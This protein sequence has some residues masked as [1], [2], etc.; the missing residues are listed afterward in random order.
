MKKSTLTILILLITTI[1][2]AQTSETKYFNS[3]WLEKEV[4]E[5]KAKF[6]QTIT[7]NVDG[8]VTTEVRDLKKNT[9][10]SSETFKGN[11]P[12]GIWK[13]GNGNGYNIYDYNF[14][15]I[16]SYEKCND[17]LPIN[18]INYFE[19]NESLGY[20]AP[21]ISKGELTFYQWIGNNMIYPKRA[22]ENGI[23]GK[24][25]LKFTITK[26]GTIENVV[27]MRSVDILLDKEAVRVLRELKFSS[28]PTLNG[29]A[30][31][32]RCFTLPIAYS[33]R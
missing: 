24:V 31:S 10:V 3:K 7:Q 27:V 6:S 11:E 14:P 15:L 13:I 22:H 20:K 29:Q 23:Q 16:Y 1:C 4:L 2:Y 5:N 12:Y 8:T 9:I 25:Y 30:C 32:F 28:P 18:T 26:E 17:T 21:I 33:L 19:D